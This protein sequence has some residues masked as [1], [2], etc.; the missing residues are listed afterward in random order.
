MDNF[1]NYVQISKLSIDY[2]ACQRA[3]LSSHKRNPSFPRT[4]VAYII[5]FYMSASQHET[6][7]WCGH[8]FL[9][10]AGHQY[11][12]EG[13]AERYALKRGQG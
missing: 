12:H 6:L 8:R 3:Y 11:L 1:L 5:W 4:M 7:L 2:K 10:A 13:I 9:A